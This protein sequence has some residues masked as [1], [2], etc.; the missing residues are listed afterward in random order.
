MINMKFEIDEVIQLHHKENKCSSI[1][2]TQG[3]Q[4]HTSEHTENYHKETL[5]QRVDF[6]DDRSTNNSYVSHKIILFY[7]NYF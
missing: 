5:R 6:S 7:S 1:L 4:L 3:I 2:F